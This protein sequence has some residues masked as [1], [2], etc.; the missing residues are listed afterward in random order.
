[1]KRREAIRNIGLT[2]GFVVATPSIFSLLQ[3]CKTDVATWTPSFLTQEEGIMVKN[4]VDVILPKT[5]IPSASE[6]NVPEFIDKYMNE[7]DC[8]C[9]ILKFWDLFPF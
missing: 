7:P 4:I 9:S 3:S 6:L 2:T 8:I 5:E 1:M